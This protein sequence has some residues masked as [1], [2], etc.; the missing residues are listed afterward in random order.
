MPPPIDYAKRRRDKITFLSQYLMQVVASKYIHTHGS[1]CR[2][3]Y[4][5]CKGQLWW[6]WSWQRP[7]H[8][9]RRLIVYR[10]AKTLNVGEHGLHMLP[11]GFALL[12]P[13][14]LLLLPQLPLLLQP[15]LDLLPLPP[16][17]LQLSLYLGLQDFTPM[18]QCEEKMCKNKYRRLKQN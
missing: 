16:F 6:R 5:R 15:R 1:D 9:W 8:H 3:K 17:F 10:C 13:P 18:L 7:R 2:K 4:H 14:Q 12:P 11:L